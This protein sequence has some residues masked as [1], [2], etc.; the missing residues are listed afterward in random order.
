MGTGITDPFILLFCLVGGHFYFDWAGQGD[1]MAASKNPNKPIPG[2]PWRWSMGGHAIIHGAFVA[3]V[4]G[5]AFLGVVEV[6]TH[7]FIDKAKCNGHISFTQDQTYH[8]L[9]KLGYFM[10]VMSMTYPEYSPVRALFDL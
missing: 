9:C 4:T 1:F 10:Y 6:F 5:Y 7:L 2:V 8:L 3:F